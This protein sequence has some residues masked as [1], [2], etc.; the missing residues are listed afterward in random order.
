MTNYR[1]GIISETKIK[2]S[3]KDKKRTLDKLVCGCDT[4]TMDKVVCGCNTVS[5][6]S[7]H[8]SYT[9]SC[10]DCTHGEC[11]CYRD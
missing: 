5:K 8:S 4:V 7:Y 6:D 3:Q 10:G 2:R 11:M 9:P 1:S